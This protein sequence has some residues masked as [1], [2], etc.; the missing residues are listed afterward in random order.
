MPEG[1][2]TTKNRLEVV[3]FSAFIVCGGW[4]LI[5]LSAIW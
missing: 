5:V 3:A 2:L 1:N 4:I